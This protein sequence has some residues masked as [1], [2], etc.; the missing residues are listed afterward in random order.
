MSKSIVKK[1]QFQVVDTAEID[2][3]ILPQALEATINADLDSESDEDYSPDE[4]ELEASDDHDEFLSEREISGNSSDD[5]GSMKL[6]VKD[7][8]VDVGSGDESDFS[9]HSANLLVTGSSDV[10]NSEDEDGEPRTKLPEI[11]PY[12]DSD[13]SDYEAG[14]NTVGNIPMEWYK[15]YPHIGYDID[16]KKVM[17]PAIGD[18]LDKFLAKLDDPNTWKSYPDDKEGKDVVL[19]NEELEII[20]KIQQSEFGDLGYDPYQPTIEWFT[21]KPEIHPLSSAPEP[22]RRFVPSK[23]EHA[24]VMKI[25]RAIRKG[26]IVPRKPAPLQPR[27][28][29][30]WKNAD[31][32]TT[33]DHPMHIPAPKVKLPGHVESYNPPEE[34]LWSKE[35][36]KK[37]EE[38]DPEDRELDF[39]P[40]KYSSL[41]LVP[42]YDRFVNDR[43]N[44]CLDLYLCPRVKKDRLSIDPDSLIPKLPDPKDLKPFPTTCSI[45]FKGHTSRIRSFSIDPT[46][47][48]MISGADD[49]TVRLWELSTGRNLRTYSFSET[50]NY[51]AWNPNKALSVIAIAAGKDVYLGC[52]NYGIA[53][54]DVV[55]HTENLLKSE[56]KFT[57][58]EGSNHKLEWKRV[59]GKLRDVGFIWRIS[60]S[61]PVTFITWHKKGDYFSTVAPEAQHS[62][63]Q[64]H[65]LS[66]RITQQPFKKSKGLAI[67][68]L[69]HPSKP[70]FFVATQRYVR[71]YDLQKQEL[72][73]KL[74]SGVK[75]ISC[76]DIHPG[77]ENLI[78]GS[79]DRRLIWWDLEL[80]VKPYKTLRYHTHA[81]R[82]TTFHRRY[83]LFASSSDDGTIQIFHGM[84]Y[85]DL[86]TNPLIVPV[87]ILSGHTR[88]DNLGVLNVEW[89]PTQPWI[90]S[91]GAD[92]EIKLWV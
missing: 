60:H 41:R 37:W 28:Y 64:I 85:N 52:L 79:Y 67:R 88:T 77:G 39:I 51:V 72:S 50:V 47:Q 13:D 30:V 15:D 8:V 21:S 36:I 48:F 59:E 54:E 33:N 81:L 2:D 55:E 18:E 65:Q 9:Q 74:I 29:D 83:P 70:L 92:G 68:V 73:K 20:R 44:R 17:R 10:E 87:K 32:S 7:G 43:F 82:S 23:W 46:G 53:S 38:T 76:M 24:K 80:S 22:K 31:E 57:G 90:I 71:I 4:E 42:G 1:R 6:L 26:L 66:R 16:G 62:A 61:K 58:E 56:I 63:I 84:V 12:T 35:E 5:E 45:T 89:H 34:Y 78:V 91:S 49:K 75:W 3:D 14:T 25:V 27:F 11:E 40:K 69:F 19:T 86:M